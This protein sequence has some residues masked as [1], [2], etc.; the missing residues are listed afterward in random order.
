[1]T[2]HAQ[3]VQPARNGEDI[4]AQL[5]R[6]TMCFRKYARNGVTPFCLRYLFAT[7]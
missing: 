3:K 7:D 2:G 1:M 5:N 4:A 6:V